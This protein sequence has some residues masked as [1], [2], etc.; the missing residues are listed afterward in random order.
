MVFLGMLLLHYIVY[1]ICVINED[2]GKH[3]YG[4]PDSV[5]VCL[6]VCVCVYIKTQKGINLGT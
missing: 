4:V 1:Y 2:F 3:N 5:S 6:C